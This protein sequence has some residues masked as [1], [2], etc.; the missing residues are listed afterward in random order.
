MPMSK[1]TRGL[2][3]LL[4]ALFASGAAGAAEK[5][6]YLLPAPAFLPA[7]GPWM[8]AKQRGYFAQEGL[9]VDFEAAQGGADAAKQVGAGNA[10]IGGAIGDTPII[11]R[12]N[13]VPVKAVALL[14]GG[15]LMQ[16][17]LHEDSPLKGPEDLKGKTVTVMAYQDTTYYAL[18]GMLAKVGLSKN[19]VN[20]EAVGATNVWKLFVANQSDAMAAVPDWIVDA[21]EAGAKIKVIPAGEYFQSMAQV[22]VASDQTIKEKPQLVRKLVRATI[23]GVTDIMRDPKGAAAD[24]VKAVP[25]RV[26]QER[27]MTRVFELYNQYVYP[28]QHILGVMDEKRLADLQDFY[29]KQG[30]IAKAT[31]VK[32]LY[33]NQFVE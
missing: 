24:Y 33:T 10:V 21:T 12:A 5:V 26:G 14:G 13:G 15:G 28:G 16:L 30:I 9:D 31:P 17:V 19:D 11:V 29:L 22:V 3:A 20:A 23:H 25:Q 6:V 32:D 4:L 27:Q 8:L 18:L 2:G 7:F 1:L